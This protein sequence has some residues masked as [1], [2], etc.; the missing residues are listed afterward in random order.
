MRRHDY[1]TSPDQMIEYDFGYKVKYLEDEKYEENL[2][3]LEIRTTSLIVVSFSGEMYLAAKDPNIS[4]QTKG[5]LQIIM[6][7]LLK[8]LE[9]LAHQE[10]PTGDEWKAA[11]VQK[12]KAIEIL[13]SLPFKQIIDGTQF[14]SRAFDGDAT[15][16]EDIAALLE[17]TGGK[18]SDFR[19]AKGNLLHEIAA[20][21]G[22]PDLAKTLE[23]RFAHR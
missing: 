11:K 12:E 2:V 16:A 17:R 4:E 18:Y 6:T 19:N 8:K 13:E 1:P 5:D 15:L 3:P 10:L 20:V 22:Y 23:E 21:G 14:F 9:V 7:F